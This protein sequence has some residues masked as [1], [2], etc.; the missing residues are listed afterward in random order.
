[1]CDSK[2][3]WSGTLHSDLVRRIQIL[4]GE[5]DLQAVWQSGFSRGYLQVV[6]SSNAVVVDDVLCAN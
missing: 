6:A 5:F 3:T 2:N 4:T 1:M